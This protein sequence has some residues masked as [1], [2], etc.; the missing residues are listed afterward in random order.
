[1]R[2]VPKKSAIP[3]TEVAIATFLAGE[4]Y[5]G[6]WAQHQA[7]AVLEAA[8]LTRPGKVSMVTSK[9]P[10]AREQ[11]VR[12][13]IRTCESDECQAWAAEIAE[14]RLVTSGTGMTCEVCGGS[15]NRRAVIAMVRACRRAGMMRLLIVGGFGPAVADLQALTAGTGL[16]FRIVDGVA[17]KHTRADAIPNLNWADLLVI[18]GSSPLPHAVSNAYT[19]DR[20]RDLKMITVVRRGVEALCREVVRAA[21]P[22]N[23]R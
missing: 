6:A 7:R 20:P 11:L 12:W 13:L 17:G 2:R 14:G 23:S 1:M 15:N 10:A 4:G 16:E 3:P 22:A 19:V 18:W 21:G 8:G 5:T 9:V